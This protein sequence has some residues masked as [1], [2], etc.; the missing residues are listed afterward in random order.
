VAFQSLSA[1]DDHVCAVSR[2]GDVWCAGRNTFNQL[3]NNLVSESATAVPLNGFK[4][5][6][7]AVGSGHS[8]ALTPAGAAWCWGL[9]DYGQA[10]PASPVACN[11]GTVACTAA[12]QAIAGGLTFTSLVAGLRW[13]CGLTVAGAVYCWGL[14]GDIFPG[15]G[16]STPVPAG[17]GATFTQLAGNG[18]GHVCG[19]RAD[20]TV[21]CW[22]RN[23]FGQL[24]DGSFD[25]QPH[26]AA[27]AVAG[28]PALQSVVAGWE[29]TCGVTAAGALYC[30]GMNDL[31][32]LGAATTQICLL[33][34][35]CSTTPRAVESWPPA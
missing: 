20:G 22:G 7:V 35:P 1:R 19:V 28:V 3:G 9:N 2:T 23:Y 31:R 29:H 26:P 24:G 25:S 10:G 4:A 5:R 18:G 15:A 27:T 30:W 34:S 13:T 32:Q 6:A 16:T 8:C 33:S 21:M 12:P 17:G 11:V 14:G